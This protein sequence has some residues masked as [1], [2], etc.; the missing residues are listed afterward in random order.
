M[1]RVIGTSALN[2]EELYT[3]LIQIEACL[4]SRPITPISDDVNNFQALTSGHFI[5]S[6]AI[7]AIPERD[8]ERVP[9]NRLTRFQ[10]L[11]QMR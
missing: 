6:E 4:N 10:L 5:I 9:I 11:A 7:N 1:R 8:F 2:F 3:I